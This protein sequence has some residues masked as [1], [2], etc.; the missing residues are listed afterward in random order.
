MSA[1]VIKDKTVPVSL[2]FIEEYM[3]GAHGE[4]VKVFLYGLASAV[5][6]READ[7]ESIAESLHILVTDVENAWKY[8]SEQ[9]LIHIDGNSVIFGSEEKESPASKTKPESRPPRVSNRDIAEALKLNPNMKDTITMVEQLLGKP[10]TPREIT[11]IFNFMDWYGMDGSLILML[12]EYCIS[13]DKKNFAYIEKVAQSWNNE[14]INDIKS[15][16]AVIRRA[17]E[18]KKFQGQC[19]KLFGIDRGFT[20]TEQKYINSWKTDL[21]FSVEMVSQAYE[22]T[23]K[24]TGKLA[25]AYMNKI[26]ISWHNKGIKTLKQIQEKDAHPKSNGSKIGEQALMDL[27]RRIDQDKS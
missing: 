23:V 19:R 13:M 15:A 11:S 20:A 8:W 24:N 9:G 2:K 1:F 25:F 26:L 12:F 10:L 22:I 3:P 18:E 7:N 6:G 16:E 14:G 27:K 5:E 17:D 21:G 4:Y